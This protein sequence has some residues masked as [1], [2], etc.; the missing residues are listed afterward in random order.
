M[1][2]W[3]GAPQGGIGVREDDGKIE[4]IAVWE[5][6]NEPQPKQSVKDDR[7]VR[8]A[9]GSTLIVGGAALLLAGWKLLDLIN[10]AVEWIWRVTR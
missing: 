7:Y 3:Y 5:L 2:T 8:L 10:Y 9:L 1:M 6:Q 4:S